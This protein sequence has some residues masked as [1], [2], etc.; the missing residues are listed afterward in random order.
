MIAQGV[1]SMNRSLSTLFMS[2]A[3]SLGALAT[4][5]YD[6]SKWAESGCSSGGQTRSGSDRGGIVVRSPV[7]VRIEHDTFA[8]LRAYVQAA[9]GELTLLGTAHHDRAHH[10]IRVDRLLLPAQTS[11]AC[12]TEVSEEALAHVLVE[13]VARGIDTA[14][15]RVW[16]HSHGL[17]EVFFSSVDERC[18]QSAFPQADW[19]LSLV[20]NLA[21]HIKARLS[22]YCP[23]RL[24][25]DDLPVTI[26]LP[27]ELEEAIRQEVEQKVRQKYDHGKA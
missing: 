27:P 10:E 24:D 18:I 11:S 14:R 8:I 3:A 26:G 9:P 7:T 5:T 12:R 4:G 23:V 2:V 21:G 17:M 1:S 16:T 22:L 19:V 15:L 20:T 6:R 25:I 13:A